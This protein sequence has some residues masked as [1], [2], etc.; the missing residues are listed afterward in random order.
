ME[1]IKRIAIFAFYDKNG[2][3]TKDV[4]YLLTNL[5]NAVNKLVVVVNGKLNESGKIGCLADYLI[6]RENKGYDAGAYK[7]AIFDDVVDRMIA[8]SEELIF[9][10]DTF[11]GP[12]ISFREILKKMEKTTSDFWGLNLSD[13]GLLTFIQSY[14]LLFRKR[15]LESGDL[16][17]FFEERIDADTLDFNKVL[18]GFERGIF[19]FLIR[20]GYRYGALNI[21]HYH[22]YSSVDASICYDKL[23]ILKKKAFSSGHYVKEKML[24]AL[25]YINENYNYDINLILA[26]IRERYSVQLNCEEIESHPI[27]I[28]SEKVKIVK[29]GKE[30][31]L[32]FADKYDNVYIY[33]AGAYGKIVKK[34]IGEGR[35]AGFIVSDNQVMPNYV[36]GIPV[37]RLSKFL[38]R[39][40]IPIIV[41][42]SEK[43]REQAEMLLCN[44][45]NIIFI[46]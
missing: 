26:D 2:K 33:G 18:L 21:Q 42:L 19:E 11:Y 39:K 35:T 1:E 38:H 40:D 30:D 20:R 32:Q 15:I 44:F 13:N 9:C 36:E 12:F 6:I 34:C 23:P 43:N 37:Y 29:S 22:V 10:N 14:F 27:Q 41:A 16:K 46:F 31:L 17:N 45:T 25:H 3:L 4:E 8:Q 5:R 28:D 24:N 7:A